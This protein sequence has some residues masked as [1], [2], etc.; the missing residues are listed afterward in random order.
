VPLEDVLLGPGHVARK[1][2]K[3]IRDSD[4]NVKFNEEQVLVVA[5]QMWPLEQA[6]RVRVE[7]KQSSATTLRILRKLPNDLGLPRV[8]VIGGGGCGKTTIIQEVVVPTLRTF[9]SKVMLT[10]PSNGA[11][12]GSD[13][14]AK[15]MHSVAGRLPQ[16]SFRTSS[17]R[18]END[19]M[20]NRV[21]AN[22][23]QAGAWV[24]DEALQTAAP[25]FH[26]GSLRTTY[27]RASACELEVARYARPREIFG[28]I[29][30]FAMCGDHLQLPP[31][32]KSS[33]LLASL[34]GTSDEHKAGAAMFYHMEYLFE[35]RSMKRFEDPTLVAILQKMRAQTGAKLS[36]AEWR[37]LLDTELDAAQLECEPDAFG[38]ETAGWFESSYLRSR[39]AM[40]SY[41]RATI[42]ARRRKQVLF[43]IARQS[44]SPQV[45]D[46]KR[47]LEV[48]DRM[49]AVPS[50]ARTSRL[51]GWV[52]LH[53]N[54]RARLT[55][56]V[57]PPWAAQ[58]ATGTIMYIDLSAQ[59]RRHL[60]TKMDSA[61]DARIAPEMCLRELPPGVYDKLDKCDQDFVATTGLWPA[62]ANRL[63]QRMLRLSCD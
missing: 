63:L 24:R 54:M 53:L 51:P 7:D 37:A 45:L 29:S 16:D 8:Y 41:T 40:A 48:Y 26:V 49:L 27:A 44:T 18:I 22:Q 39:V 17:L 56:Q 36:D 28:R 33:G 34:D 15:A 25:L 21:D 6:W 42:S 55:T 11:A 5:L 10:A 23:T 43:F 19:Q 20:R 60:R 52:L 14:R 50:V 38:K 1:L 32:L 30:F 12:R 58:D 46:R 2:I 31:V 4:G 61:D 47:D 13:P 9:F 62:Q 59:D 3:A 35:M 57:L